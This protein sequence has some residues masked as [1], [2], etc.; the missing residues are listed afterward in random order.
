M[1]RSEAS[2]PLQ[3]AMRLESRQW[4]EG[5]SL[6]SEKS[7]IGIGKIEPQNEKTATTTIGKGRKTSSEKKEK[8]NSFF[9]VLKGRKKNVE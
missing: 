7:A 9:H 5:K 4:Y 8:F 3:T 2:G 6:Q 1:Y